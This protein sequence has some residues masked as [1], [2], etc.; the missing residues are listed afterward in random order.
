MCAWQVD[1]VSKKK[2]Y[3]T[4]RCEKQKIPQFLNVEKLK[5]RATTKIKKDFL[6]RKNYP[7]VQG[8][9]N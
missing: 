3:S 2:A 8:N 7:C 6:L 4:V 5:H 1:V 9:T